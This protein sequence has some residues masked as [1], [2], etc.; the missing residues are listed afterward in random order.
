MSRKVPQ[1]NSVTATGAK[2][3]QV[4][5]KRVSPV[6]HLKLSLEENAYGFLNESLRHYRKTSRNIH[7]WPFALL[8]IT[9]SLE[10][11]LKQVLK[12]IHPILIYEDID[13]PKADKR[14]VSLERALTRLESLGVPIEEKERLN[15]RR[16]ALNRNLVVHYEVE[17]NRFEWKKLYARLFEFAHF[18]HHKHLKTDLHSHI[19]R[20]NW[21][22]EARLML[23]FKENFVI[24]NGVEMDKENPKDIIEAQRVVGFSDGKR[25]YYRIKYGEET[26]GVESFA[27]QPCPDCYVV[28]G[29]YHTDGCD[30]EQCPGCHGQCLGCPCHRSWDIELVGS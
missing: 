26:S 16:A 24:Y 11:M 12:T 27:T 14:T 2:L 21:P 4:P 22:I 17:L 19:T 15:I 20:D 8:H 29:Q 3:K 9:Q 1:D 28:K 6:A 23:F 5:R 30:L 25:N 7:E 18:F 13:Q 10:L